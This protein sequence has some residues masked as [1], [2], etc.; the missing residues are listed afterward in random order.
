MCALSGGD[1]RLQTREQPQGA[2]APAREL[3]VRPCQ[4]SEHLRIGDPERR[5]AEVARHDAG[6]LP[7]LATKLDRAADDR[8]I[9]AE[10]SSPEGMAE[11]D[12]SLLAFSEDC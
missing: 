1:A 7:G 9:P 12:D 2:A 11:H 5:E 4:G 8:R 10:A 3:F 6:D